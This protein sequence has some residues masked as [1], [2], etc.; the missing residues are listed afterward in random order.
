[1][2]NKQMIKANDER[3]QKML[4]PMFQILDEK[5]I[6][7]G[8][9]IRKENEK[10]YIC[11]DR[12]CLSSSNQMILEKISYVYSETLFYSDNSQTP[13]KDRLEYWCPDEDYDKRTHIT[14]RCRNKKMFVLELDSSDEFTILGTSIMLANTLEEQDPVH[15]KINE[16]LVVFEADIIERQKHYISSGYPDLRWINLNISLNEDNPLRENPYAPL[17]SVCEINTPVSCDNMILATLVGYKEKIYKTF[18]MEKDELAKAIIA[19][20]E[21]QNNN[22]EE[23]IKINGVYQKLLKK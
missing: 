3:I 16:D 7:S 11:L 9:T 2:E 14:E 8:I 22:H 23:N 12:N 19:Y 18:C 15:L 5:N 21:R 1:M 4:L 6:I 13:N 10:L 20:Y 17:M